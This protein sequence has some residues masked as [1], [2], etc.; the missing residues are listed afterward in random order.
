MKGK[1]I[2]VNLEKMYNE[3]SKLRFIGG[4]IRTIAWETTFQIALRKC[5]KERGKI[6]FMILVKMGMCGQRLWRL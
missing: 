2:V 1:V 4:K 3:S 6:V 5:S